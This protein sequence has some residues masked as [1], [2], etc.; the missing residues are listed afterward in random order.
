MSLSV[1]T[2]K[3]RDLVKIALQMSREDSVDI[4]RG[5][6]RAAGVAVFP[7]VVRKKCRLTHCLHLRLSFGGEFGFYIG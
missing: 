3:C 4:A 6:R 7:S 5:Q 2:L 1:T